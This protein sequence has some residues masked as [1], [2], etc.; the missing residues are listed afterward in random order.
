[1]ELAQGRTNETAID[2]A[3][4]GNEVAGIG[5]DFATSLARVVIY[6]MDLRAIDGS[7]IDQGLSCSADNTVAAVSS[8]GKA[9]GSVAP[10]L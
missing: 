6:C 2:Q 1:M 7:S 9:T 4:A 5:L 8:S 3:R 10:G